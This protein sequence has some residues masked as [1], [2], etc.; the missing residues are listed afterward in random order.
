MCGGHAIA[1]RLDGGDAD[2]GVWQWLLP[3][4]A[5]LGACTT[6]PC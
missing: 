4:H 6:L 1:P 3:V 5:V 2:C